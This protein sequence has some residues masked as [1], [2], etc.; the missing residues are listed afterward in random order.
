MNAARHVVGAFPA[1]PRSSAELSCKT[2]A[3]SE[4]RTCIHLYSMIVFEGKGGGI[5]AG[6]L[7]A[8][9]TE[10]KRERRRVCACEETLVEGER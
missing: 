10:L 8:A 9:G 6:A 4:D 1:S 2:K 5:A 7:L 3:A